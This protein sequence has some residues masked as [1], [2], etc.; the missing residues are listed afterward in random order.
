MPPRV[1]ATILDTFMIPYTRLSDFTHDENT[2]ALSMGIDRTVSLP[3]K[4]LCMDIM[5]V[6]FVIHTRG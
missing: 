6:V 2:C 1:T 4:Y 3:Q 5:Y